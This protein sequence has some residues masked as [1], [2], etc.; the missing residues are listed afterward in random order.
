M[1]PENTLC[2][3]I[4][5]TGG[6]SGLG[7]E[8][9]KCFLGAGYD[10]YTLGRDPSRLQESGT[11]IHF[12]KTD[13][14]D[15]ND[16]LKAAEELTEI[17]GKFDI[18]IN[19]AGVLSPPDYTATTNGIEYTFQVNFLSQLLL[20]V[21]IVKTIPDASPLLIASVT[22]PLYKFIHP[23]FVIPEKTNYHPFRSYA[24][25]KIYLLLVGIYLKKIFPEKNIIHVGLDPG[26][27]S[28]GIYRMQGK[29]FQRLYGIAAP[30]MRRPRKIASSITD[31]I[32]NLEMKDGFVIKNKRKYRSIDYL[33][34]EA[35]DSFMKE[36]NDIIRVFL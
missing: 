32:I 13:L 34:T 7:F 11:R 31:V 35:A 10:V 27:F 5:I 24:E 28:S 4:L 17:S 26:T 22:S 6:T 20:N 9:V 3:K 36:C 1:E 18:I 33:N 15:L 25:S 14:S 30:F 2:K 16:V 23:R 12:I 21:L 8:L 29:W 19:N